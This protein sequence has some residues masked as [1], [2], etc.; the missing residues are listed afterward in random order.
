MEEADEEH[1][2]EIAPGLLACKRCGGTVYDQEGWKNYHLEYHAA[3]DSTHEA[4]VAL[5]NHVTEELKKVREEMSSIR[6]QIK[7]TKT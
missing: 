7:P 6:G 5:A 2:D 1:F 4:L 3:V